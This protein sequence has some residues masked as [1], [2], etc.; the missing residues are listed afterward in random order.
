MVDMGFV[1]CDGVEIITIW[2][3]SVPPQHYLEKIL[4]LKLNFSY[5]QE[6]DASTWV[7]QAKDVNPVFG[8]SYQASVAPIPKKILTQILN[9][10]DEQSIKIVLE[11]FNHNHRQTL[12]EKF[13][14]L[15]VESLQKLW[16][17]KGQELIDQ[18]ENIFGQFQDEEVNVYITTL[19]IC[20]YS[21]SER[22]FYL[23][24]YH[25]LALNF[26]VIAHELAHFL[27]Y[28][29]FHKFCQKLGLDENQFQTLK[30][31]T[32][33][34]LNTKEFDDILLIEDQGYA[35]HEK[36]RKSIMA[37]WDK[38]RDLKKIVESLHLVR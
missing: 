8:I 24:L 22:Y 1:R 4:M 31:S 29:N 27:F 3:G 36:L 15:K 19:Y 6:K 12:K 23:S 5:S 26:T 35:P 30:E 34:L 9:N 32:T 33:V 13:I 20:D 14:Q 28:Q 18:L 37:N 7:K 16:H 2:G 21:Y 17:K 11:Y 25:S 10:S 38:E